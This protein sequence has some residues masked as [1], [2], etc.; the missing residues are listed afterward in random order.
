MV[1]HIDIFPTLCELTGVEKPEWLQGKSLVPLLYENKKI[2]EEI[3]AEINYHTSYEPARCVRNERY[4]Y[5]KYFDKT[6]DK[7]NY[8]NMDDSEVKEFLVENGLLDMK[9]EMEILYDLYF[10]PGESSN[11]AGKA[12]YSGILEEMR[13]KLQ[14]WQEKTDDPV[15]EGRIEA[16]EGA[17]INNKE[18]MSAGSKNKNDYEKFPD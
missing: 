7:Y 16:P 5:I 15:L 17:K 12:E 4:K 2:R 18:C 8:S 13:I 9:K 6:Y 3:Y 11:V 14:E 1:S 10:D